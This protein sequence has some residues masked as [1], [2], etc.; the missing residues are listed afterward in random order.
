M[1]PTNKSQ[2]ETKH[3]RLLRPQ[4]HEPAHGVGGEVRGGVSRQNTAN[5]ALNGEGL[6]PDTQGPPCRLINAHTEKNYK[7]YVVCFTRSPHQRTATCF[8][9]LSAKLSA[10]KTR[11]DVSCEYNTMAPLPT[12]RARVLRSSP[13]VSLAHPPPGSSH[14]RLLAQH[15]GVWGV[16]DSPRACGGFHAASKNV[17][18]GG[19]WCVCVCERERER[20]RERRLLGKRTRELLRRSVGPVGPASCT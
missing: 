3:S 13:R 14:K 7:P 18:G 2:E 8:P 10:I 5:A 16:V 1:N 12:P 11:V 19:D 9:Q 15:S 4:L 17:L 6:G 20:E